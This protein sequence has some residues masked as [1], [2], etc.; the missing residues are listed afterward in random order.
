MRQVTEIRTTAAKI[1][2]QL[3]EKLVTN[4]LEFNQ[5]KK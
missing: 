2:P 4:G 5:E 3:E 1:P